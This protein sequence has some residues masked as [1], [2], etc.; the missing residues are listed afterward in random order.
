VTTQWRT[1]PKQRITVKI[2]GTLGH[3]RGTCYSMLKNYE[4][5]VENCDTTVQNCVKTVEHVTP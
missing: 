4:R 3:H 5:R 2:I 1:V